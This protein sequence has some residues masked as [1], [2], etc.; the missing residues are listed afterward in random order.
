M[1]LACHF[2]TADEI[3]FDFV[4]AIGEPELRAILNLMADL[5]DLTGK[6]V[7]LTPENMREAPIFRYESSQ[8]RMKGISLT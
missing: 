6:V 4:P 7:V 1:Q 5:G 2:F 3:E 8:R